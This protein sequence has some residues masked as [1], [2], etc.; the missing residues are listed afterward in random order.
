MFKQFEIQSRWG[1]R[2]ASIQP[3]ASTGRILF[4]QSKNEPA[5]SV[6]SNCFNFAASLCFPSFFIRVVEYLAFL[7]FC[8]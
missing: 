5:I 4:P 6:P 3:E 8:E 7:L 2:V 1:V